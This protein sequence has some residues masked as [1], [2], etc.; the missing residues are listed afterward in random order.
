MEAFGHAC[1]EQT[2]VFNFEKNPDIQGIFDFNYDVDRILNEL[3]LF[4]DGRPIDTDRTLL[5]FDEIQQCPKAIT[6]LKYFA[7]SKK[8]LYI[9]CAGSLLGVELK[10]KGISFPVGKIQR[11]SMYPMNFTE[12]V[13]ALG[14]EQ[15]METLRTWDLY[16]E[17]PAF[18]HEPMLKYLTLYYV[19]GGMPAAVQTYL[20]TQDFVE[21]D[22]VL[23]SI[24]RDYR[25]DFSNHA[26]A[27]DIIRIGYVWDSV[28]K[29]LAKENNKFVFSHVKE[30]T[31]ARD[32]EDAL[33]WLVD[34]GL[35]YCLEKVGTPEMPLSA[36]ADATY[37]KTYV[38]DVGLLRK[39]AG[40]SYRAVMTRAEAISQFMGAFVENYC[41][42][43]LVSAGRS[44]YFWRNHATAEVD[45]L[46]EADGEVI[47][48][49][50]KAAEN[51][52]AK[53]FANYC[54]TYS[55][56]IGF[57]LSQKNIGDNQ[58]EKTHEIAL[59]LYLLWKLDAYIRDSKNGS[60]PERSREVFQGIIP[61]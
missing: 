13:M 36:F 23:D 57:R 8:N 17:I 1:F 44:P 59:P 34:A 6:S 20:D 49:E 30:G 47:P 32:L 41:M 9:L 12:F 33:R 18:L 22:K 35:V 5:I 4:S 54:R 31:R 53:S 21:V 42:T 52:K 56:R 15:Q 37:F 43:E 60:T 58:K 61:F 16:R 3:G 46:L 7:E 2:L 48:L 51:T 24:L 14:G 50:A 19:I 27:K 38:S 28:P 39:K 55:P 45:F 26:E 29:Q 40:I 11:L 25:D 10:R